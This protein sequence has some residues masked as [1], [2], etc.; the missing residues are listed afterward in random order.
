[1]YVKRNIETRSCSRYFSGKAIS[2]TY[3][4]CV[5]A[6][7]GIRHVMRKRRIILSSVAC[8]RLRYFSTLYHKRNDFEKKNV[9]EH[10]MYKTIFANKCTVY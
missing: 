4:E 9:I 1:M 6:A 7:L 3:S 2:S 10:K 5:S 8:P